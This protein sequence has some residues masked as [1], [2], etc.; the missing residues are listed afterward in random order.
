MALTKEEAERLLR[1]VKAT[2]DRSRDA[3]EEANR[4]VREAAEARGNAVQAALDA[5][6]PRELI[7]VSA[8]VHRNLLYRIAGK[9]S[10]QKKRN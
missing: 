9:T 2:S 7:A 5:G 8:G 10:Q 3:K 1:E 6:L 4:I